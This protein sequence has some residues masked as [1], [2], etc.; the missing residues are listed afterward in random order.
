MTFRAPHA[1]FD[2]GFDGSEF[3][4]FEAQYVCFGTYTIGEFFVLLHQE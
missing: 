2:I 1:S 4:L 3:Y